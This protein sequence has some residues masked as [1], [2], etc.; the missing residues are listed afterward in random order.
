MDVP[1]GPETSHETQGELN[2]QDGAD[3]P[4]AR[5][6]AQHLSE[7]RRVGEIVGLFFWRQNEASAWA[8]R[9]QR[10]GVG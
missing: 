7:R 5:D 1:K 10:M 9:I 2:I 4:H 3:E 8:L 6:A